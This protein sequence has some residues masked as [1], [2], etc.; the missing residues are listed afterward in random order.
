M[1]LTKVPCQVCNR[2][3]TR[4][5]LFNFHS[6][7]KYWTCLLFLYIIFAQLVDLVF[8]GILADLTNGGDFVFPFDPYLYVQ[9]INN[10]LSSNNLYWYLILILFSFLFVSSEELTPL[11]LETQKQFNFTHICAGASAFGKVSNGEW[12]LYIMEMLKSG[13]SNIIFSLHNYP[14][15]TLFTVHFDLF[16]KYA[17]LAGL[18]IWYYH[19]YYKHDASITFLNIPIIVNTLYILPHPQS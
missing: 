9:V 19:V 18:S 7:K 4:C 13:L 6:Q 3:E 1:I 10:G 17:R 5:L 14:G 15:Q 8:K 2:K 12:S 11:I 16:S